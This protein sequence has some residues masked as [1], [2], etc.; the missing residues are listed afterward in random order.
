MGK[1]EMGNQ[2]PGTT[3]KKSQ[4]GFTLLELM[5]V[6]TIMGVLLTIAQPNL[7]RSITRAREAVLPAAG[8]L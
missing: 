8:A 7:K 3:M 4:L 6:L 1:R 5:I 2:Y